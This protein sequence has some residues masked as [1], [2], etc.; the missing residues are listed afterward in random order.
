MSNGAHT[1]L[2]LPG[3]GV[4]HEIIAEAEATLAKIAGNSGIELRFERAKIGGEAI[5]AYGVP[6]RDEDI[7]RARAADAVLLGAVGGP[8]WDNVEASIRPERGLLRL[9]QTL[10]LYANLRPV[11]VFDALVDASPLK[12]EVARGSDFV[13]VRELTG[14]IYFGKPSEVRATPEGREAIDTLPYTEEEIERLARL[15]FELAR[16]RRKKVTSVDKSNVMA[17]SRLWRE[18]VNEV[19]EDYPDITLEH[20]LVDACAMRLISRPNDFDVLVM[21]NMFGDILSDEAAVLAGSLGMLPSASL[22]TAQNSAGGQ[23][24]VYEPV[25]GSAPDIAGQGIAN[26]TGAILSAAALLRY[27]FGMEAEASTIERAVEQVL[28]E[29]VRTRD[30]AGADDSVSTAEFGHQVRETLSK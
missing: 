13:I 12:P 20:A 24:G 7:E 3:D 8:R 1:V 14:G 29:G 2:L 11:R 5:D 25:H 28:N 21:E 23:F 10:G 4:G 19:A 18:I 30:I 17:T 26:P 9:R 6:L 22:G 16:G 15:G 27:S